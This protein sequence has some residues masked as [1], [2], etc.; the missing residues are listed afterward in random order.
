MTATGS[1]LQE[2]NPSL[3]P[4][5]PLPSSI[6]PP[7]LDDDPSISSPPPGPS[8]HVVEKAHSYGTEGETATRRKEAPTGE[9][10]KTSQ[11]AKSE[12]APEHAKVPNVFKAPLAQHQRVL[13]RRRPRQVT[14]LRGCRP[15]G[16]PACFLLVSLVLSS[17]TVA[18]GATGFS[19]DLIYQSP[20]FPWD[21]S[22]AIVMIQILAT[23]ALMSIR[24]ALLLC[25]EILRRSLATRGLDFLSFTVL[26]QST[27]FGSLIRVLFMTKRPY[28][29]LWRTLAL[30]RYVHYLRY[31]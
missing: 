26:S 22:T 30:L 16:P 18:F 20:F 17:I 11:D 27:G 19:H 24:E 25:G 29:S 4:K 8:S 23:L 13:G 2:R 12:D 7:S 6:S 5:D 28:F 3:P 14:L 10:A 9:D 1:R 31:H 21:P 15:F